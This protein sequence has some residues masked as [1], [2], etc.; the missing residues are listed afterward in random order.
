M[1]CSNIVHKNPIFTALK[2]QNEP[3]Y[4]FCV[5]WKYTSSFNW[6]AGSVHVLVNVCGTHQQ[7]PQSH[8]GIDR[9]RN[10][11]FTK[12]TGTH[13]HTHTPKW[14]NASNPTAIIHPLD[15]CKS[16][17]LKMLKWKFILC[18]YI[19]IFVV[20]PFL[21]SLRSVIWLHRCTHTHTSAPTDDDWVRIDC[22]SRIPLHDTRTIRKPKW[23]HWKW[24][25]AHGTVKK[26]CILLF[27]DL[28][29]SP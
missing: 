23:F 22:K 14:E 21:T 5:F 29:R 28:I 15:L 20:V 10:G 27:D 18:F 6:T 17:L 8:S 7:S 9:S 13:T 24:N 2:I 16:L 1:T 12:R 4:P 25:E 3:L 26:Y 19:S 11:Q